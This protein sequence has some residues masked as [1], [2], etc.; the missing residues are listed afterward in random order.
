M[1]LEVTQD[2]ELAPISEKLK[3]LLAIADKV[4]LGGKNVQ[5]ADVGSY[6]V[7]VTNSLGTVT[8]RLSRAHRLLREKLAKEID[9]ER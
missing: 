6:R 1:V 3:A 2:P 8:S 5:P 7:T 9:P 4:L